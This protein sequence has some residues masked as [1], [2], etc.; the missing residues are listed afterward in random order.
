MLWRCVPAFEWW[1]VWLKVVE[2]ELCIQLVCVWWY[3]HLV[4]ANHRTPNR[5]VGPWVG[6]WMFGSV[7]RSV[8]RSVGGSVGRPVE[9]VGQS[10]G[11]P[12]GRSV[13]KLGCGESLVLWTFIFLRLQIRHQTVFRSIPLCV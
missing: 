12:V 9:L 8:G 2:L 6:Q 1:V 13:R 3:A 7:G 4:V 10:V 11:R 5:S